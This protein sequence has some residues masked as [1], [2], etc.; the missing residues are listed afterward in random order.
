M[1]RKDAIGFWTCNLE[2]RDDRRRMNPYILPVNAEQVFFVEDVL[3]AGWSVVLRHE[4]RSRR[5]VGNSGE[6]FDLST[7]HEI[8]NEMR[9]PGASGNQIN[10]SIIEP[11]CAREIPVARVAELDA[12]L[13]RT[14]DDSHFEDDQYE[15][16]EESSIPGA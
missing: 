11:V 8:L 12:N 15:D 7:D 4:P 14:E 10:H 6:A 3:T 13:A 1:V 2:V 9:R 16:E 5:V